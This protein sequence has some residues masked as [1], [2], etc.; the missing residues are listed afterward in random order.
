VE[1]AH[2][3]HLRARPDERRDAFL[4]LAGGLVG[5]RDGED[6]AGLDMPF[7]EQVGDPM[8]EHAGLAGARA[9]DDEQR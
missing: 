4:H 5:E 8:R 6:L 3:H 2:P 9:R 7:G 1:R